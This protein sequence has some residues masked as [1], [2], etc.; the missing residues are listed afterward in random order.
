[1]ARYTNF[2]QS[3]WRDDFILR[4]S[5]TEKYFYFYLITNEMTTLWGIYELSIATAC[6]QTKLTEKKVYDLLTS[7][8]QKGKIVFQKDTSEV[9]IRNWLKY[10]INSSPKISKSIEN[11]LKTIKSPEL[12][13][14]LYGIDRVSIGYVSG[15]ENTVVVVVDDIVDV[16]EEKNKETKHKYGEYNH[17]LLTDKEYKKLEEEYTNILDLIAYL[18]EYIEMKGYKAKSHYLAIRK[19]VVD[20]VKERGGKPTGKNG[21]PDIELPWFDKYQKDLEREEKEKEK[22]K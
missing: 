8:Q 9:C 15:I 7:L 12:A 11:G 13:N 5:A 19:W 4:L 16:F 6:F 20:A 10:N 17:V 1:M 14:Y 3:F 2:Y 21:K 18:D 22:R